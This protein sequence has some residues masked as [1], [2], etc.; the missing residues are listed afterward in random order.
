MKKLDFLAIRDTGKVE[1]KKI[2]EAAKFDER[3]KKKSIQI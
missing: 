2:Q 3:I 1:N